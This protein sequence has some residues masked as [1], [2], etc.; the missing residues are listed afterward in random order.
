[1]PIGVVITFDDAENK[2]WITVSEIDLDDFIGHEASFAFSKTKDF[3]GK[4]IGV[5]TDFLVV[6]FEEQPLGLGQGSQVSIAD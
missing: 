5:E 2:A 3:K 6:K 4:V 1:M